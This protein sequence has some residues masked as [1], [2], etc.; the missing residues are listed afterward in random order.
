MGLRSSVGEKTR[1]IMI[2]HTAVAGAVLKQE[3][4][5]G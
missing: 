2:L 1:Q 3:T 5:Q 4:R